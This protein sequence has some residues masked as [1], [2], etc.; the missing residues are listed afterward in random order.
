MATAYIVSELKKLIKNHVEA[1]VELSWKGNKMP[2]EWPEIEIRAQV[3]EQQL[4]NFLTN[5]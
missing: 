4:N 5:L 1:Q 2:D 3:A